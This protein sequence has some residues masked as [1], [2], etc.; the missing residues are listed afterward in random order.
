MENNATPADIDPADIAA[1]DRLTG[2]ATSEEERDLMR[3]LL[4]QTRKE[5][6]NLRTSELARDYDP[7]LVFDPRVPGYPVPTSAPPAPG[8]L[9][10]PLLPY[11]GDPESLAFATA[12]DL[13]RL[14]RAGKVTSTE[15]TRMYLGRLQKY[16]PGLLCV[17]SVVE[18]AALGE[19]AQADAA[20]AAGKWRGPLH[21][22]PYGLKDLFAA[23]GTRT[24]NGAQPYA[25]AA[26]DYDATV[27]A[28]LREAGAVLVAKLSMGELAM[29]DVWFGGKTRNPWKPT[30]G[31]SG[32]SAGSASAVAAGLVGFAIGTETYGSI[33]SPCAACG[34]TGLRPTYGRVPRT[35][36]MALSWTMDKVGPI[37]RGVEDC[38]LVLAAIQGP[39]GKDRTVLDVPFGWNPATPLSALRVG[40]DG[41][42]FESKHA[43]DAH[44]AVLETLESLGVTFTPVELPEANPAYDALPMLT[45]RAEGAAAFAEL[46]ADGRMAELAQQGEWNWPNLLRVGAMIP[47]ADYLQAQRVR[48][49]LQAAMAS[50]LADVDVYVS[51]P[52]GGT[53]LRYTNLSGQPTLITRC[54]KTNEGMPLMIEFTGSLLREDAALRIAHAYEQA[55][56]FHR[57]WPASLPETPPPIDPPAQRRAEESEDEE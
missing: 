46:L 47:A 49:H 20:I 44:R 29:G 57:D 40:V 9:E 42:S 25:D 14:L 16:G 22:I 4:A 54:G 35:G 45:I 8:L 11:N 37:C 48:R 32:S 50:A 38:A 5:L 28:R 31:S 18:E 26:P 56:A 52:F 51:V 27:T 1:F 30:T 36:G 6:L 2:R 17:V 19:A 13:A 43:T 10:A 23:K 12:A 3:G 24:T 41:A 53:S 39:D 21:G 33:V 15:L 34:T 55:T 7:A